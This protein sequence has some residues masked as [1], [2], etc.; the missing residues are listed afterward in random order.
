MLPLRNW[1][2][3]LGLTI[4]AA[5]V[6][7]S[8]ETHI[9]SLHR[10]RSLDSRVDEVSTRQR[11]LESTIE[12]E[13]RRREI[14]LGR[15]RE[16]AA[17]ED[18]LVA[19]DTTG[20]SAL[21]R[22][23]NQ[24][25]RRVDSVLSVLRTLPAPPSPTQDRSALRDSLRA[26]LDSAAI[27]FNAPS[28]MRRGKP[29]GIHLVLHPSSKRED[30]I[31]VKASVMEPEGERRYDRVPVA[32]FAEARLTGAKFDI[33]AVNSSRQ[34]VGRRSPTEWRWLVT[35]REGGTQ[36]L[37]LTLEVFTPDERES[38]V[39][40]Y[41]KNYEIIVQVSTL[42]RIVAWLNSQLAWMVPLLL[43][44]PVIAF[45]TRRRRRDGS[46]DTNPPGTPSV[47]AEPTT[48]AP[49]NPVRSVQEL[50]KTGSRAN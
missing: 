20:L 32:P 42:S 46:K 13:R 41:T 34:S 14:I 26:S 44:A 5:V 39:Y 38:P 17:R 35:P 33:Q 24:E 11:Q 40:T 2:G 7:L 47:A 27:A 10:D 25:R 48:D 4:G 30:S 23:L 3:L 8:Y 45:L 6:L 28:R 16:L 19:R 49:K 50:P 37:Y 1:L 43:S 22:E 15:E 29:I 21:R 18:E 36:K 31:A 9:R 12:L